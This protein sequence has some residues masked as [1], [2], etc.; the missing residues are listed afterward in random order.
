MARGTSLKTRVE[1]LYPKVSL[2]LNSPGNAETNTTINPVLLT[3]ESGKVASEMDLE[4]K[5]GLMEHP[6]KENGDTT[7]T[8][9][10]FIFVYS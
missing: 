5:I 2:T 9:P 4:S 8:S 6:M 10:F 1:K 7:G 3:K